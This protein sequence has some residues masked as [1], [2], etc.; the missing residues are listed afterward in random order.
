[1]RTYYTWRFVESPDR[2]YNL[3]R[4]GLWSRAELAVI[5]ITGCLPTMPKFVQHVRPKLHSVF[6]PLGSTPATDSSKTSTSPTLTKIKAPLGKHSSWLST[7]DSEVYPYTS[8]PHGEYCLLDEFGTSQR[9]ANRDPILAPGK[10][11]A[12]RRDDL[13]YGHQGS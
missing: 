9:Q 8:Q 2:S 13:E 11:V 10:G 7:P 4:Y 3:G 5:V 12:T 1:M 6:S